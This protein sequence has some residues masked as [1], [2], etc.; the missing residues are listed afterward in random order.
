V[1]VIDP[2]GSPRIEPIDDRAILVDTLFDLPV[3]AMDPDPGDTL[4]FALDEAPPGMGIDPVS[5]LASWQPTVADLGT[6]VVR[7]RATDP[8]GQFDVERFEVTVVLENQPPWIEMI[9]EQKAVPD[10]LFELV[11]DATDPDDAS[12]ALR[13]DRASQRHEHRSG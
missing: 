12:A 1:S 2:S 5:G 10:Q 11:V 8:S 13:A 3:Q 9:G 6:S 4:D 7:V